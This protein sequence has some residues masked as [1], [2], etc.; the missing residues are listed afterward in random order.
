MSLPRDNNDPSLQPSNPTDCR[1]LMF[2]GLIVVLFGAITFADEYR[3]RAIV[4]NLNGNSAIYGGLA[5]I[6]VILKLGL[7]RGKIWINWIL[8]AAFYF[9]AGLVV[10]SDNTLPYTIFSIMLCTLF[11]LSAFSRISI[12]LSASPQGAAVGM[13]Y[14][15]ILATIGAILIG[16]AL[17]Y[18]MRAAPQFIISLDT[19]SLGVSIANFG[20]WR[21]SN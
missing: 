6:I 20:Y 9:G 2:L 5:I 8:A 12:G 10:Q 3:P 7:G 19:I 17:A 11:L 4:G 21:Q 1:R 13:F 14:S 18:H 15:G 16:I